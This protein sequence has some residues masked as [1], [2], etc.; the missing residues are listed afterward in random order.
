MAWQAGG[1]QRERDEK[2]MRREG[3]G[4]EWWWGDEKR[5]ERRQARG[6]EK[7]IDGVRERER[8]GKWKGKDGTARKS[9][10]DGKVTGEGKEWDI[11]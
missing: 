2:G 3:E 6:R 11:Y 1:G 7:G 4:E 10:W 5:D 8:A 9:D